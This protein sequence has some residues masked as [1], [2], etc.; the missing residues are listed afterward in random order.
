MCIYP[1][2]QSGGCFTL[3]SWLIKIYAL[4]DCSSSSNHTEA[5]I[6]PRTDP[7]KFCR[8][9]TRAL[10]R[11]CGGPTSRSQ[12]RGSR[13]QRLR[14]ACGR[15]RLR[16]KNSWPRYMEFFPS[17]STESDRNNGCYVSLFSICSLLRSN[18][19]SSPC[20][21]DGPFSLAVVL[22]DVFSTDVGDQKI[23]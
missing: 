19:G 16:Q 1:P 2:L 7:S 8:H 10:R 12:A 18:Q 20:P 5:L 23:S 4:I 17:T 9:S 11:C 14:R 13:P 6:Q 3:N 15:G 21:R 22:A